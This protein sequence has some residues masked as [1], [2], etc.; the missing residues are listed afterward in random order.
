MKISSIL[1]AKI[2][3]KVRFANVYVMFLH[4][5]FYLFAGKPLPLQ[6]N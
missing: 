3:K 4:L 1:G 6:Q 5:L 2:M